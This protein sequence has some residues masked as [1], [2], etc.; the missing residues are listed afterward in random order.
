LD[1][2][3]EA[4]YDKNMLD[5]CFNKKKKSKWKKISLENEKARI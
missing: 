3:A 5:I 2:S 1:R 4:A